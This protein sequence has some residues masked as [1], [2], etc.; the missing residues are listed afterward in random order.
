M[1]FKSLLS[2]SLLASIGTWALSTPVLTLGSTFLQSKRDNQTEI[3]AIA[4]LSKSELETIAKA[5]TVQVH[6]GEYRGSGILIARDNNIYTVIT[7]AH[8]VERRDSYS[9][10]TPDGIKHTATLLSK[11]GSKQGSD[12]A[13]LKFNSSN[14]YQIAKVGDSS[15]LTPE[16]KV[17]AAGF[18]FDADTLDITW[19]EI[20]LLPDKS[21]EGG[22]QIGF[23]NQT[24]QGMSGGVLLNSQGEVIGVLGKG[25]GAIFDTAYTYS[26]GTNPTAE[27]L[28]NLKDA[29]FSIPIAKVAELSPQLASIV[30]QPQ[31]ARTPQKKP[32]TPT[33]PKQYRGIVGKV[34]K[35]A[36]Q[37][38]VRIDNLTDNSNGSGVII[39]RQGN[40]YYVATAK[41]ILCNNLDTSKCEANGQHQIVTPDGGI[42]KLDYQTLKASGKWLDVAVFKFESNNNYSVATLGTYD[43]GGKW[44]FVSGFPGVK[45]RSDAQPSR[46]L[47]RGRVMKDNEQD[48][49]AKDVYSLKSNGEG[50]VYTNISYGGMSG[51]AVLDSEGRLVGIN[52]GAENEVLIDDEGNHEQFSLGY[53]LGVPILDFLGLVKKGKMELNFQWLRVETTPSSEITNAYIAYISNIRQLLTTTEPNTNAGVAVWMNYG[54]QLWRYGRYAESVSAFKKVIQLEPNFDKAYYAM[55]L[56]FWSQKNYQQAVVAL[57]KATEINSK[58]YY[59]WRYLGSSYRSLKKYDDAL[60]AYNAAIEKNPKDFVLYVERG[61]VLL[62]SKNYIGAIESCTQASELNPDHPWSYNNRGFVYAKLKQYDKAI[63]DY[64]QAI[65]INP[66]DVLTYN[67]RG[68]IYAELKKYKE[69]LTNYNQAIKINPQDAFAYN[70]RANIYKQL[71]QYEKAL[72]NLNGLGIIGDHFVILF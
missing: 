18:P 59:Y 6:V 4:Q 57:T 27:E 31:I 63:A 71:K 2:V 38:T 1:L 64:N 49:V 47:T 26:D 67:N 32:K 37:I 36:E 30:P 25:K 68:N 34:D 3:P 54:N 16:E 60:V 33:K 48:F 65:K 52:T 21:L 45:L 50:L 15:K 62:D 42:H 61:V 29:S 9:V 46:L 55:G 39:A 22:Y 72:T 8:V 7:N 40:I 14:K 10:E 13:I 41:H 20:S 66:Q 19:G 23:T 28:T 70:N 69:A 56:A 12:L 5:I 53:S 44:V 43:V 58:P 11:D 24:R 17:I 51:G 35:I